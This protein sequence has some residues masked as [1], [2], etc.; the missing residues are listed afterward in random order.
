M[1]KT[2]LSGAMQQ[3]GIQWLQPFQELCLF[4][5]LNTAGLLPTESAAQVEEPKRR[6]VIL[7]TGYGKTLC[8]TLPALVLPRPTLVIY[9]LRALM[10]DQERRFTEMGINCVSLQGG[11]TNQTREER[12]SAIRDGQAKVILTNPEILDTRLVR[13]CLDTVQFSHVVIDE[14]HVIEQWGKGFRP[15]YGSLGNILSRLRFDQ[16]SAFTA[17]A[18]KQIVSSIRGI[19]GDSVCYHLAAP[20]DRPEINYRVIRSTSPDLTLTGLL[21]HTDPHQRVARPCIV[22]V[23]NRSV[24]EWLSLRLSHSACNGAIKFYHAGLSRAEKYHVEHWFYHSFDGVLISTNA[25]GMGVD[26]SDIRTVIHLGLP[27]SVAA[28]LQE[29]GRAGRDRQPSQA[30]ALVRHLGSEL[31]DCAADGIPWQF[32]DGKHCRRNALVQAMQ[33]PELDCHGCDVCDGTVSNYPPEI[34]EILHFVETESAQ[35]LLEELPKSLHQANLMR[36]FGKNQLRQLLHDCLA[37]GYI[38]LSRSVLSWNRLRLG[39]RPGLE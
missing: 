21:H 2:C 39:K 1:V 9:P 30:I 18:D 22:F 19:M 37:N 7:P 12:F 25:Y 17:T 34:K 8:F 4:H 31:S 16:L 28:Y 6:I 24:C 13:E 11:L 10:A 35:I 5:I 26:K 3:C 33:M 29:S 36:H 32:L 38:R 27:D 23:R 14:A 15:A 20:A